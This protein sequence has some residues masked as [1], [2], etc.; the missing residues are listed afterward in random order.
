MTVAV[1][2]ASPSARATRVAVTVSVAVLTT[3]GQ[4]NLLGQD[5]ATVHI[6]VP[7]AAGRPADQQ[8]V[9]AEISECNGK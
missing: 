8:P 1:P 9:A 2:R 7:A 4:M 3:G 6:T 5:T